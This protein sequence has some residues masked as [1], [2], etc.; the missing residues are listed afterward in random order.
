MI[1]FPI[2]LSYLDFP[3]EETSNKNLVKNI[4]QFARVDKIVL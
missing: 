3:L 4:I 2:S 1:I